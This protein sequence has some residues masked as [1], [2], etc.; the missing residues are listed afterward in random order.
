MSLALIVD[1]Q[2]ASNPRAGS[3]A[4]RSTDHCSQGPVAARD[5]V[6]KQSTYHTS[7][8]RADRLFR[9]WRRASEN[10]GRCRGDRL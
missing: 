3:R 10:S 2:F 5:A 6:S 7:G 1:L 8:T 9:A 4:D